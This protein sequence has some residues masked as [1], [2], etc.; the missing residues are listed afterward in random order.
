[1]MMI[2]QMAL[3]HINRAGLTPGSTVYIRFWEFGND[4]NGTFGICASTVSA[5]QPP[6]LSDTTNITSTTATINWAAPVIVPSTGYEYI[7][8]TSSTTPVISGVA[9]TALTA[10]LT[11]LTP[12][13]TYYIFV[14]SNCGGTFSA[15]SP[16][17]FF[18]TGYC[19]S[20][21]TSTTSYI[22]N[23]STT[24]GISNITNNGSGFSTSGYGNFVA[25]SASQ[26]PY[27]TVNFSSAYVGGTFG[28]N[29][30]IDWNNDL[31]FIDIG[32]KVYGSGNFF[33]SNTGSFTVP[34]NA[35]VGSHRMRIRA[36]W[37]DTNPLP[38][39]SITTGE[40]EDYTFNVVALP[41]SGNPTNL[42]ATSIGFTTATINWTAASPAPA[43]GYEYIYSTSAT[44][45]VPAT[46]PN[47]STAAGITTANLTGLSSGAMYYVWVRSNC[48]ANK[49]VWVGPISL[50]TNAA[51]PVTSNASVCAGGSA[52]LTA[53]GSCTNL[54]NLGT[55]VNGSWDA[56]GD[57]R[58]VRPIIFIANSP[59]CQFDGAGLTSNYTSLDFQ[60]S[61]TG[62][63]TFTMAPTTAYDAMGYIV[64]NP[65]NPGVC[66]SGTWVVGDDDSGPT[67]F[68]PMMSSTLTAGVTYTLISTL[69]SGSSITL[70]NTFQW[71]VAG[72]GTISGVVGGTVEWYTAAS[73]GVPIGTGTPFNPVGVSG[74]GLTNTNTPGTYP[75]YAAC[76]NNPSVRSLANF[77]INGLSAV[78]SGSGSTCSGSVPL[79]IT[80][81][82]NSPW[83]FTYTNGTTP[84]TVNGNTT[85][86]YIF[87][88]SPLVPTNYTLVALTNGTCTAPAASLTGTGVISGSKIGM[89]RL[90]IGIQ[91]V[92]GTPLVYLLR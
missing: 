19:L 41:C 90:Q 35:T 30:W 71:N 18:E 33:A 53:T 89:V 63:Y 51:P 8:S 72:P 80:F 67:T 24:G 22:N 85:N 25:Q 82:G 68:E 28:F 9:T 12:N 69:Y 32:E 34:A 1:M 59:I 58:A 61:T 7:V 60:V 26:Q 57:P 39:G 73:G 16:S 56:S 49:G 10:N 5:C 31:D 27:G 88:V 76:A 48:G 46:P 64:I 38:C 15:W 84:V 47:G 83:N 50:I 66:G 54:T 62:F 29:I 91:Q 65:F 23:F 45:P 42:P 79:S 3:C 75:F 40:T 20:T 17:G 55:T 78:I 2:V 44:A 52:T 11:G 36:N 21:S 14:R 81:T 92:I 37:S 13:T 4:N 86:P 87:N 74:S 6:T 77:V 70:T 43:N